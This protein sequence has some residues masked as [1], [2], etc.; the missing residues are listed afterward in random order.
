MSFIALLRALQ[1]LQQTRLISLRPIEGCHDMFELPLPTGRKR[2]QC[3]HN[4]SEPVSRQHDI[5][6][7]NFGQLPSISKE[8]SMKPRNRGGDIF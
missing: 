4:I 1:T 8:D 5:N 3:D 2:F 7:I 6:L